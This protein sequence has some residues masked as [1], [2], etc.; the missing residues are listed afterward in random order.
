LQ[1]YDCLMSWEMEEKQRTLVAQERLKQIGPYVQSLLIARDGEDWL[2]A[3][4]RRQELRQNKPVGRV[5]IQDPRY[6][7]GLIAHDP[8][9]GAPFSHSARSSAR[10]L[11]SIF[12]DLAHPH[13]TWTPGSD[14]RAETIVDDLLAVAKERGIPL[15]PS[16]LQSQSSKAQSL[17]EDGR[18]KEALA[19][20]ERCIALD[21]GDVAAWSWKTHSLA[22][23]GRYEISLAAAKRWMALD[24]EDSA[25]WWWKTRS[26]VE[27]GR[28]DEA[29]AA[30][31]RCIALDPD[32]PAAWAWKTHSLGEVGRYEE[33]LAAA[34]RWMALDPDDSAAWAWKTHSLWELGRYEEVR[35]MAARYIVSDPDDSA[36]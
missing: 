9:A 15:Q 21:P 18:H 22:E 27:L 29:L 4:I 16:N 17:A 34:E 24:P 2:H 31:E 33:A 11:T 5:S 7:A 10:Q 14:R 28:H 6:L 12:T 8:V 20:A 23:L 1:H 30:A 19:A 25:A 3:A 13:R 35:A 32:D 26:L 36:A